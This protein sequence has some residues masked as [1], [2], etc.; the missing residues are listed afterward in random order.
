MLFSANLKS[1]IK[2]NQTIGKMLMRFA[3]GETVGI[4]IRWKEERKNN[5]CG[6]TSALGPTIAIKLKR[7]LYIAE[8]TMY[9]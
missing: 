3:C 1:K 4:R 8:Y 9:N 7:V 6:G 2:E 5:F